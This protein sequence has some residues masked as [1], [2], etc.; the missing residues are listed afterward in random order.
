MESPEGQARAAHQAAVAWLRKH[1]GGGWKLNDY[2]SGDV[3]KE[4]FEAFFT[5][6]IATAITDFLEAAIGANPLHSGEVGGNVQLSLHPEKFVQ[7]N[8][9]LNEK[10][11]AWG[12]ALTFTDMKG[13]VRAFTDWEH[14]P[15]AEQL[16]CLNP[17]NEL[18]YQQSPPRS[19]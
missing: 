16:R 10:P 18:S 4:R 6:E 15:L 11:I 13:D 12:A 8:Q 14:R 7:L 2:R 5:P 19:R 9:R 17:H 3:H 1:I